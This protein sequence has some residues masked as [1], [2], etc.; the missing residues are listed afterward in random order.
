MV[1]IME[2]INTNQKW[3]SQ[4]APSA[5]VERNLRLQNVATQIMLLN[6]K[7]SRNQR[8]DKKKQRDEFTGHNDA[9]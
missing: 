4:D 8:K 2:P 3:D 5:G 6:T 1:I 7:T 9:D